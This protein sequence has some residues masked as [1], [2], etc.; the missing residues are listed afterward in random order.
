[1]AEKKK[2]E[3]QL[4]KE[5]LC[6]SPKNAG[7]RFSDSEWEKADLFCEGYKKFLDMAK[8]EREAV[9][10]A[11]SMAR[12][13]GFK[14]FDPT[15]KYKAGDRVFLNNRG[16]ALILCTVGTEP[17]E[18]GVKIVASHIDSPRLD[19]KPRPLYEEAQLALF[20]TH[21]YGGI[22]KYQWTAIPLALH[23]VVVRADGEK[24]SVIIGEDEGDPVFTV[25]DLLPHLAAE[26]MQRKAT[27]LIKGEALNVLVGGRM[28]KDD[29]ESERVKLAVLQ[30]LNEKYGIIEADFL[31]A[32]LTMV[33]AFKAADVGLDRSFIGAYGHDDRVCAYTSL[34][35]ALKNKKPST[36]VVTI[37]SD[38]EETGSEGNSGLQS[39]YLQ[40]FIEDLAAPH[41]IAGRTVLSNSSCLSADVNAAYD[42]TYSE[43]YERNN[44]AYVNYGVVVTKYT[45]ARGKSS[46]NDASAEFMGKVRS[47]L[48]DAGVQWQT[49]ELGKV[50]AGGGGTVAMYVAAYNVDVVD[51]GVPV[52]SMHAPFEVVAKN[53]V[54]QTYL[55][56]DAYNK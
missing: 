2:T 39:K 3:A 14:A 52:L 27:D 25:S 8:T 55:A 45:G 26:Q 34:M 11:I 5:K 36:T 41:G 47:M 32:E 50:D 46:T 31:S 15:V 49:G 1:M 35:A 28:F 29:K 6:Y 19:L 48:D 17:I 22:K 33:P 18:K 13:N 20:K 54:Y 24:V 40:Y 44:S 38:K 42:P 30:L 12:E 56:F 37:L 16:K 4:L 21:Y 51:I 10:I 53:D 9:E 23:G 43:V 7:E